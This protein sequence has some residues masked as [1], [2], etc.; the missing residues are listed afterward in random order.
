MWRWTRWS[1]WRSTR[2]SARSAARVSEI[3]D[4]CQSPCAPSS[5]CPHLRR[6]KYSL[7]FTGLCRN[8]KQPCRCDRG[9]RLR[10]ASS[11][12][13]AVFSLRLVGCRACSA[14]TL[15]TR[16]I[17]PLL[18]AP[19][20]Q[21]L[22]LVRRVLLCPAGFKRDANLRMH[23]RGHGDEYKTAAALARPDRHP[24]DV[25]ARP[26]RCVAH[27]IMTALAA[28]ALR[29]SSGAGGAA[30]LTWSLAGSC[31]SRLGSTS[32]ALLSRRLNVFS[33]ALKCLP[34]RST[35]SHVARAV[36]LPS[37][38][39]P[40]SGHCSMAGPQRSEGVLLFTCHAVFV[41][42]FSSS[43]LLTSPLSRSPPLLPPP[44]PP[45]VQL[46]LRRLQAQ[47]PAPPLCPP[48]VDA[49]REEPLPAQPLPQDAG[50]LQV[51]RQ[52]LLRGGGPQ[53][54][55]EALRQGPLGLL[56]RHHLLAQGQA[57]GPPGALRGA[58]ARGSRGCWRRQR[59]SSWP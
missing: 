48:Q 53:D 3:C 50:L 59:L 47:P 32:S 18:C 33:G 7:R 22:T 25:Q 20:L 1:C 38:A 37:H 8:K 27:S 11:F 13:P 23:M 5:P 6:Q 57:H 28:R 19:S 43:L 12:W 34:T 52:A 46:P 21:C 42:L 54:A 36:N 30:P 49:L 39:C 24:T 41:F 56:L 40:P 55:R 51:R 16:D 26:K 9:G 4:K 14:G 58:R 44:S 29:C 17:C 15:P 2:T 45:Q 10:C 31:G 35:P